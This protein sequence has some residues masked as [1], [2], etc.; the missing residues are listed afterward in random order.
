MT[1]CYLL[2]F[3]VSPRLVLIVGLVPSFTPVSFSLFRLYPQ[4]HV[5]YALSFSFSLPLSLRLLLVSLFHLPIVP[6]FFASCLVLFGAF[7]SDIGIGP[8]PGVWRG[9]QKARGKSI[10]KKTFLSVSFWFGML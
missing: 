5:P 9:K 1:P 10:R 2:Y 7:L 8:V 3:L 4:G 6:H